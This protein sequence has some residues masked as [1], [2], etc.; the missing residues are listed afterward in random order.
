MATNISRDIGALLHDTLTRV[1]FTI[2]D[3]NNRENYLLKEKNRAS[4]KKSLSES[5]MQME[6]M[7]I[8]GVGR[9]GTMPRLTVPPSFKYFSRNTDKVKDLSEKLANLNEKRQNEAKKAIELLFIE[10]DSDLYDMPI[11]VIIGAATIA[12]AFDAKELAASYFIQAAWLTDDGAA[13]LSFHLKAW[14][15]DNSVIPPEDADIIMNSLDDGKHPMRNV[16]KARLLATKHQNLINADDLKSE[17]KELEKAIINL[18]HSR[19]PHSGF[20]YTSPE[21]S[22]WLLNAL[23]RIIRQKSN[24]ISTASN[25]EKK[26]LAKEIDEI[27]ILAFE[28][29]SPYLRLDQIK[30]AFYPNEEVKGARQIYERLAVLQAEVAI[31]S[32]INKDRPVTAIDRFTS[33]VKR[34]YPASLSIVSFESDVCKNTEGLCVGG[35]L[36]NPKKDDL[37]AAMSTAIGRMDD[38]SMLSE[39]G[40]SVGGGLVGGGIATGLCYLSALGTRGASLPM[41]F[42]GGM[43]VGM[44]GT[45]GGMRVYNINSAFDEIEESFE[46]GFTRIPTNVANNRLNAMPIEVGM[47]ALFPFIGKLGSLGSRVPTKFAFQSAGSAGTR[48]GEAFFSQSAKSANGVFTGFKGFSSKLGSGYKKV[49]NNNWAVAGASVLVA[50]DVLS[51]DDDYYIWQDE[52][53]TSDI[54]SYGF[55]H[56]WG[57]FPA[58]LVVGNRVF[59]KLINVSMTGNAVGCMLGTGFQAFFQNDAGRSPEYF[60]WDR[61]FAGYMFMLASSFTGKTVLDGTKYWKT[62]IVGRAHIKAFG[63]LDNHVAKPLF[64]REV[65]LNR[66]VMRSITNGTPVGQLSKN[67]KGWNK[68]N[69]ILNWKGR[70]KLSGYNTALMGTFNMATAWAQGVD[71]DR[72]TLVRVGKM[73]AWNMLFGPLQARYGYDSAKGFV[74]GKPTGAGVEWIFNAVFNMFGKQALHEGPVEKMMGGHQNNFE[75]REEIL[76]AIRKGTMVRGLNSSKNMIYKEFIPETVERFVEFYRSFKGDKKAD[77]E[78]LIRSLV[79]DV[80]NGKIED[81]ETIKVIEMMILAMAIDDL[82]PIQNEIK[83]GERRIK[84]EVPVNVDYEKLSDELNEGVYDDF[85]SYQ[86]ASLFEVPSREESQQSLQ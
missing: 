23:A 28:L 55:S 18:V 26:L 29:A 62:S 41:C 15:L 49:V 16:L 50:A 71:T 25:G 5:R 69:P 4:Q 77:F 67:I 19:K 8:L 56:A 14:S 42:S 51:N 64:G 53:N 21:E 33:E 9:Y 72:S 1:N 79:A 74:L 75:M 83:F 61:A 36:K 59:P 70:V 38:N 85:F 30:N 76:N 2:R 80:V 45:Y 60:D 48:F 81:N 12:E 31:L 13:R 46:T 35:V 22:K 20:A 78:N 3:L 52:F 24:L 68:A 65:F 27:A 32:E 84:I 43:A 47:L 7:N 86:P 63:V 66:G 34:R 54:N 44:I 82:P 10:Y 6:Q 58:T 40:I 11:D 73:W 57:Y 17:L 37:G 39:I